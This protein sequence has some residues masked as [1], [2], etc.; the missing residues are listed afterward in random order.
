MK[1][2]EHKVKVLRLRRSF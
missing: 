1:I 2:R